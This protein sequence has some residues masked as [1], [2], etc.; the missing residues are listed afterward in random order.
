M[1]SGLVRLKS[2]GML[3]SLGFSPAPVADMEGIA[4][5]P[6]GFVYSGS[7]SFPNTAAL[8][9]NDG[10]ED[11]NFNPAVAEVFAVATAAS[12]DLYVGGES[13]SGVIRL[14][15]PNGNNDGSF[16]GS[17]FDA[18]SVAGDDVLLWF[19]APW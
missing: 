15:L 10:I 5:A 3:D 17:G 16:D 4:L 7:S 6:L 14:T 9:R 8:W 18:A 19:W 1:V 13:A 12:G 11:P 2:D